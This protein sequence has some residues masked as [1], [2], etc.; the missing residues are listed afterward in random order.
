MIDI[1]DLRSSIYDHRLFNEKPLFLTIKNENE[2]KKDVLKYVVLKSKGTF[3]KLEN[4]IFEGSSKIYH[5]E[6]DFVSFKKSCDGVFLLHRGDRHFLIF[7]EIK[8][9][10][11]EIKKK[12]FSQLISSYVRI[13]NLLATIDTYN[14]DEYEEVGLIISYPSTVVADIE[15]NSEYSI[16]RG[17]VSSRWNSVLNRYDYSLRKQCQVNLQLKHFNIDKMHITPGFI[18]ESFLVRHIDVE[19]KANSDE[20]DLDPVL[21]AIAP[22]Y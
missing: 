7:A 10:F 19:S 22:Q 12:A 5:K 15:S 2:D 3:I 16:S 6:D 21:D 8:S 17:Y 4:G 11:E 18:N 9:G 13:K 20:I 1:A 14:N